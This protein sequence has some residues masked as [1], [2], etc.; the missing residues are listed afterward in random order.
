MFIIEGEERFIRLGV[1]VRGVMREGF[2][3][4]QHVRGRVW[5]QHFGEGCNSPCGFR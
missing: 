5:G 4:V 1:T 3:E 2:T